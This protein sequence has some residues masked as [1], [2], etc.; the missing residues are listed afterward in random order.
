MLKL[1][2]VPAELAAISFALAEGMGETSVSNSSG[3]INTAAMYAGI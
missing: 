2:E 1:D 3:K